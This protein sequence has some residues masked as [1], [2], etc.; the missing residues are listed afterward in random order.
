M[1]SLELT[2]SLQNAV[3]HYVTAVAERLLEEGVPVTSMHAFGAY[4]DPG[5]GDTDDVEG[6]IDFGAAFQQ[7]ILPGGEAGLHWTGPSGWCLF[8]LPGGTGDLYAGARWLGAGLLPSPERVAE[9]MFAAQLDAR[10]VGSDERP[11]YRTPRRN[12]PHLL[13]RLQAFGD[14]RYSYEHRFRTVLGRSYRDRI[15]SAL[16]SD[17]GP[18]IDLPIRRGE[19]EAI[20]SFL[21]YAEATSSGYPGPADIAVHLTADL[22][23]RLGHGHSS[24]QEHRQAA[25]HARAEHQRMESRRRKK[26]DEQ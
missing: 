16:R 26:Q 7:S 14:K 20:Q 18:I 13:E 8:V 10:H 17:D 23:Q 22:N 3:G 1:S 19:L 11:F 12:L 24:A 15:I 21:G 4:D 9:F 2:R 6:G 25:A 5:Q